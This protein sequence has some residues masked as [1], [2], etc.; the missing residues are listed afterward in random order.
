[1]PARRWW[2]CLPPL[3]AFTADVVATL[4]GQ[5]DEYWAGDYQQVL[6]GNPIPRWLLEIS[7]WVAVAAGAV[8]AA[9]FALIVRYWRYGKWVA[10]LITAG[11]TFG[12]CTW[13]IRFGWP[14]WVVVVLV[15]GLT[16]QVWGWC[17]RSGEPRPPAK[18]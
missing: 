12:A 9:I 11:H 10:V 2:L 14:G 5:P 13:L 4:Q 17:R 15:F 6:E 3:V 8:W 16:V 18:G 7:P 1:M